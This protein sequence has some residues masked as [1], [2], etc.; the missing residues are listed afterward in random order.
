[1]YTR[2]GFEA[3]V[4]VYVDDR[5]SVHKYQRAAGGFCSE[6]LR[7][8]GR[9]RTGSGLRRG[10]SPDQHGHELHNHPIRPNIVLVLLDDMGFNDVSFHGS[11]QIPT[12]RIDR[13][14]REGI[15]LHRMYTHC[16]CSPSRSAL[17]T[18]KYPFTIGMQGHP[19]KPGEP[20]GL[21]L[22]HKLLPEYMRQLGYSTHMIGKWHLGDHQ[23]AYLPHKRGFDTFWGT[24]GGV[25][26]YY[27]YQ[28]FEGYNMYNG[29]DVLRFN[30][31]TYV[32]DLFAHWGQALIQ[33]RAAA[34]KPFFLYFAPNAPRG[35]V[36]RNDTLQT[37]PKYLN[38]PSVQAIAHP[39]RRK[40]A[41][42]MQAVDDAVGTIHD[43]IRDAG[44]LHNTVVWFL[45]D[46]GGPL[47]QPG[48]FG[49]AAPASNWPLRGGKQTLFE[50]G[51]RVAGFVWGGPY[52]AVAGGS[53]YQHPMHLTDLLPTLV[54]STHVPELADEHHDNYIL[55]N[56]STHGYNH[57]DY[58]LTGRAGPR[59]I[60]PL[61]INHTEGRMGLIAGRYKVVTGNYFNGSRE[62]NKW[63]RP[64][65]TSDAD[66]QQ[67][68]TRAR[69]HCH[70][71]EGREQT[72]CSPE[73]EVCLF[74]LLDDPCETNNLAAARPEVLEELLEHIRRWNA[75]YH[76]VIRILNDPASDPALHGGV[77]RPWMD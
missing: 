31:S 30:E 9:I 60:T 53:L 15:I 50:G 25:L 45:S 48:T 28:T 17:L 42:M 62:S 68:E 70:H 4:S 40:Y 22:Q 73:K 1:M 32:T 54:A 51:V 55:A 77:W 37:A 65:G 13:L 5:G 35:S 18:G 72:P 39:G 69:V 52:N 24:P 11:T 67:V 29:S 26:D 14:A 63:T 56:S 71:P 10:R 59:H 43:A 75:S 76:P 8:R 44:L 33:E 16:T 20:W 2:H 21:P 7:G 61:D 36:N 41:A 57:W 64:F 74:D 46:N 66:P 23:T 47:P 3:A 58:I 38:R 34:Q 6:R 12:P 49:V 27:S 19:I